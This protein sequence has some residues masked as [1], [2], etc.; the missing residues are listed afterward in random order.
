MTVAAADAPF[1]RFWGDQTEPPV[2][3]IEPRNKVCARVFN[4][5]HGSLSARL[6]ADIMA[7][8]KPNDFTLVRVNAHTN[9]GTFVRTVFN[10]APGNRNFHQQRLGAR[11]RHPESER[12]ETRASTTNDDICQHRP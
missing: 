10:D 9:I 6:G 12:Q 5:S 8:G 11:C 4:A 1:A 2:Q 7:L 3:G